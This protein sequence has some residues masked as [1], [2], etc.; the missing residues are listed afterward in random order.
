M[1][2]PRFSEEELQ[3]QLGCIGGRSVAI[4]ARLCLLSL[5]A[6]LPFKNEETRS[7]VV[8][9]NA[10]G[11]QDGQSP[12]FFSLHRGLKILSCEVTGFSESSLKICR[13]TGKGGKGEARWAGP[14][15]S[16]LTSTQA[17]VSFNV[18]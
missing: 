7:R 17:A 10:Q 16:T 9:P 13:G 15:D 6:A 1:A 18:F 11:H 8:R 3:D 12:R 14:R 4:P 2:D 5:G